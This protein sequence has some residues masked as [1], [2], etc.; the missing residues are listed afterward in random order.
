VIAGRHGFAVIANQV[1]ARDTVLGV[2]RDRQL[3]DVLQGSVADGAAAAC[4]KAAEL[5][6]AFGPQRLA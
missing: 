4:W 5:L 1:A 2:I 3:R 6:K